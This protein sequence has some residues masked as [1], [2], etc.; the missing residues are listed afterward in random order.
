MVRVKICGVTNWADAK[1]AIDAGADALGF[2]F[3]PPSPRAVAPAQARSEEHTSE[4]QSQSNLVCRL[5]LE[6]KKTPFS[7]RCQAMTT[8]TPRQSDLAT[9]RL[10]QPHSNCYATTARPPRLAPRP[11]AHAAQ[12]AKTSLL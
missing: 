4:L 5:L 6:K 9:S 8:R 11:A 7:S 2:N 12:K 3:Y 10:P 1:L